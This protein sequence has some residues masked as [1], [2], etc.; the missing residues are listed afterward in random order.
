VVRDLDRRLAERIIQSSP[1]ASN[2]L[3]ALTVIGGIWRP[4]H[5]TSGNEIQGQVDEIV[6][7]ALIS[8]APLV[9]EA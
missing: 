3:R 1:L 5:H 7:A 8:Y 2:R 4:L 9:S 6:D